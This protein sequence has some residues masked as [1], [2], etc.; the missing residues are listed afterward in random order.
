M[1]IA[2]LLVRSSTIAAIGYDDRSRTL[3]VRFRRPRETYAY[4][5]VDRPVFEGFLNAQSKGRYFNERIRDQYSHRK[6]PD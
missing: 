5:E 1:E 6:S 3:L 2:M 4:L